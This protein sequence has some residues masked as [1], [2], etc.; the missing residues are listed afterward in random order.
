MRTLSPA[1]LYRPRCACRLIAVNRSSSWKGFR[2]ASASFKMPMICSSVNHFFIAVSLWNELC[3]VTVLNPG[4]RSSIRTAATFAAPTA[5][6]CPRRSLLVN[7]ERIPSIG[8]IDCSVRGTMMPRIQTCATKRPDVSFAGGTVPRAGK[9][10]RRCH[11]EYFATGPRS[12]QSAQPTPRS[13]VLRT[14]DECGQT[15]EDVTFPSMG[16]NPQKPRRVPCPGSD[17]PVAASHPM[18]VTR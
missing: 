12:G 7:I 13:A 1:L 6:R 9:G 14:P 10:R 15:S 17:Q 2:P 3:T 18:S 5:T 8:R 16:V 4:S 11:G